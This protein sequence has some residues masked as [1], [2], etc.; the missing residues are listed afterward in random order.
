MRVTIV[1]AGIMGLSTA[2][3]LARG[4]H[5]VTVLDQGPVP[6]PL[7]TSVDEHR[8]IRSAYGASRGY[9]T[10]VDDAFAAWDRMWADLGRRH[11]HETGVLAIT[12]EGQDDW[13]RQSAETLEALGRPVAWL[14][15]DA[16]AARYPLLTTERM[17]RAFHL[18]TGGTLYAGAIVEHLARHLS[19]RGVTIRPHT[20]VADVDPD[21][22]RVRL[23]DGTVEDADALVVAAGAWIGR[24]VPSVAGRVTPS[25]QVV[26]YLTPPP[27]TQAAWAAMPMILEIDP[28]A[29]FYLVPPV[30]GA[31]LKIGDHRFSL[32]GDPDLDREAA[33]DEVEDIVRLGRTRIRDWDRYRTLRAKTCFYTVERTEEFVVERLA[34]RTWAL[35]P[36]SGHGFKFGAVLGE[37]AARALVDETWAAAFPDWAA[38]R[39]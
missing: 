18:P 13:V 19:G 3:A 23:A 6:N 16:F 17:V 11:Y 25:R 10:M 20:P 2:W 28:R 12:S 29:G 37:A 34:A 38:G 14:D 9:T 8:L 26:V 31:G 5:S 39:A 1:G 15:R 30:P 32:R 21:R 22:A 24:L 35:S 7:G 36:C 27:E 4:G 33:A